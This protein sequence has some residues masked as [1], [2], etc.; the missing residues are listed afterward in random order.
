MIAVQQKTGMLTVSNQNDTTVMFFRGGKIISTRD[1]R[2]KAVDPFKDYLIRYGV[3][4][5]ED[6][7]RIS[8]ISA[9][10]KIDIT[11]IL[12]SEELLSTDEL[13]KHFRNQIQ[14][15]MHD[16]LSWE[17]CTYKFITN[18]NIIK[19]IKAV[20]EHN[21]EAMLMESMR[22]IDEFPQLLEIIPNDYILVSRSKHTDKNVESEDMTENE[23]MVFSQLGAEV[24][25]R[26]LI[27]TSKMTLFEVY[28]ALK[29]LKDKDLI[30]LKDT[31]PKFSDDG[32]SQVASKTTR[33]LRVNVL[34]LFLSLV[35]FSLSLF[36]GGLALEKEIAK[37]RHLAVESPEE[38]AIARNQVT[39]KLRWLI[40]AYRAENGVYPPSLEALQSAGLVAPG[41]LEEAETFSL[42]YRLTPGPSAYTLH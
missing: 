42:R 8:Q 26:D 9:Q 16:V 29:L 33:K 22:R 18:D 4:K 32:P 23:K 30:S 19:N 17:Q 13:H 34:P 3:L 36:V 2:R 31:H 28:E 21:I 15:S 25:V 27:A 40:E 24:A 38:S 39:E 35:L 6:L 12:E 14:E 7:I 11:E 10:S 20:G 37:Q 5:R 41:V 1:R